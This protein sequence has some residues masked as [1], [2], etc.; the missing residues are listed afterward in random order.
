M[1]HTR[2]CGFVFLFHRQAVPAIAH[3]DDI[4]PQHGGRR[5]HRGI[6][7]FPYPVAC[8]LDGTADPFQFWA[9]IIRHLF[10][11][12]DAAADLPAKVRQICE[13]GKTAG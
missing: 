12:D 8:G 10:R 9:G 7:L 5:C 1:D 4:V 11:A 3:S 6:Q 2:K 13:A